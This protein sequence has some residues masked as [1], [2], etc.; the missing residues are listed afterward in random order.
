R[1]LE[2][3]YSDDV[4]YTTSSRLLNEIGPS[5]R[6]ERGASADGSRGESATSLMEDWLRRYRPRTED[7]VCGRG[8]VPTISFTVC[9]KEAMMWSRVRGPLH[10]LLR[11]IVENDD[12]S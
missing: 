8:R 11:H 3:L 7:T 5:D 1:N 6:A 2:I 12:H 9:T 10:I 4:I